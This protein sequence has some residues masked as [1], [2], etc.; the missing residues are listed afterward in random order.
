VNEEKEP[1]PSFLKALNF[2][3]NYQEQ[4]EN[5]LFENT[6]DFFDEEQEFHNDQL[7]NDDS[8]GDLE[9]T[10]NLARTGTSSKH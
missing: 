3:N 2:Y 6:D 10:N 8:F 9:Q 5:F 1:V 4:S 7:D